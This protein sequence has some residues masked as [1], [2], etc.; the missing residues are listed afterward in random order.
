MESWDSKRRVVGRE[1][2]LHRLD[3]FF[4]AAAAV[5]QLGSRYWLV[6]V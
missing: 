6:E 4:Y 2:C 1:R 5:T 3:R